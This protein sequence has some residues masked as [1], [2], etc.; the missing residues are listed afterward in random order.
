VLE[1][2]ATL[3]VHTTAPAIDL[4]SAILD[5]ADAGEVFLRVS[6]AGIQGTVVRLLPG[7]PRALCLPVDPGALGGRGFRA[8]DVEVVTETGGPAQ[9]GSVWAAATGRDRPCDR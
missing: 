1:G 5:H 2:P 8:L 6:G 9:P 3:F 4:R 7:G